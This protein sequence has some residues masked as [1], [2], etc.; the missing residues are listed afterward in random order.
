M[1]S[2]E[3]KF[4]LKDLECQKAATPLKSGFCKRY[5]TPRAPT[6]SSLLKPHMAHWST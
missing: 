6:R 4:M 5:I 2:Q 3:Y 1:P